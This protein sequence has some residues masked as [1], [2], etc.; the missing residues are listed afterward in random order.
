MGSTNY[1]SYS[2]FPNDA[3]IGWMTP[4]Y[5]CT[6]ATGMGFLASMRSSSIL[7]KKDE[8]IFDVPK[9]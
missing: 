5:D 6:I 4:T 3:N 7:S 2:A 9:I 1:P 8:F